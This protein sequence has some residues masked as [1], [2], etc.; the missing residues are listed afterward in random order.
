MT[1]HR[2]CGRG[3]RHGVR[4]GAGEQGDRGGKR[5][6]RLVDLGGTQL[7]DDSKVLWVVLVDPE[8]NEFCVLPP[9]G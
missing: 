6:R 8:G 9:G 3:V 5:I 4:I 2:P 7:A 1:R